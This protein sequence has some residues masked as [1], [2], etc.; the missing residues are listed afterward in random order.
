MIEPLP[1]ALQRPLRGRGPA[2][3]AG[4]AAGSTRHSRLGAILAFRHTRSVARDNT[5][6]VPLAHAAVAALSAAALLRRRARRG[7]GAPRRRARGAPPGADHPAPG[8][9]RPAQACCASAR[10]E[11]AHD[12]GAGARRLSASAPVAVHPARRRTRL[13]PTARSVNAAAPTVLRSPTA[14]QAA[15]WKSIQQA[16]LQGLSMRATARLRRASHATPSG[17]SVRA[18]RS[19]QRRYQGSVAST[20]RQRS[21]QTDARARRPQGGRSSS[22]HRHRA[23]SPRSTFCSIRPDSRRRLYGVRAA[24]RSA[25]SRCARRAFSP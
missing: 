20:P 23:S 10:S 2:A 21:R 4:L 24:R 9:P 18:D 22:E 17:G 8:S 1:A 3:R 5:R 13:R 19:H 6:Q 11:L 16:L 12:L 7:A 15:R 14:R 25:A